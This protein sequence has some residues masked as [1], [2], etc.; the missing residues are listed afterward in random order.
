MSEDQLKGYFAF[1]DRDL[2]ANRAGKP[3]EKQ[4]LSVEEVSKGS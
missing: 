1:D 4:T 3:S 2:L